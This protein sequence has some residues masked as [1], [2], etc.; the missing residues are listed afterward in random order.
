MGLGAI[1]PFSD[2][3]ARQAHRRKTPYPGPVRGGW[4]RIHGRGARIF[5]APITYQS[6]GETRKGP[7]KMRSISRGG[8]ISRRPTDR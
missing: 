7:R 2:A 8:R 6:T 1:D 4:G 3:D 5:S